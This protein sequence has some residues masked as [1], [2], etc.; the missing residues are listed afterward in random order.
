MEAGAEVEA[1][2]EASADL[3]LLIT[4][5]Q[6]G[7]F[8]QEGMWFTNEKQHNLLLTLVPEG[9]NHLQLNL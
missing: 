6:A 5:L 1:E 2:A 4:L 8:A 3:V 7:E 9:A